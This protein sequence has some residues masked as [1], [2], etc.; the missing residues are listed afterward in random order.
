MILNHILNN[1][2]ESSFHGCQ[3]AQ[4]ISMSIAL[5]RYWTIFLAV[6]PCLTSLKIMGCETQ[7]CSILS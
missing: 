7:N 3:N 4:H 1:L 6:G 2:M 5:Q